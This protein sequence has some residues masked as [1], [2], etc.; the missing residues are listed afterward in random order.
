MMKETPF[1]LLKDVQKK[2]PCKN[3]EAKMTIYNALPRKEYERVFM[4]KTAKE[5][6][7]TLIITHQGNSQVKNCKIDLLTQ[8]YKKFSIS[9]EETIDSGSDE[10]IYEEEE[11]EAFN[12]MER[13]F[14]KFFRKGN[15]FGRGNQ[16][17]N[18]ANRFEN[19]VEIV[20]G[21]KKVKAQGKRKFATI[22]GKKGLFTSQSSEIVER[23]H[24][25]LRKMSHAMLDEQSIPQKWNP[26]L[27]YFRVF[28]CKVFILKTKVHLTK[29]DPKSYKG[30]FLGY[31]QSS[32]EYIVL[33]KE[34]IRIEESLNV[35]FAEPKSSPSVEDDRIIKLVVQNLVRS[36]LLKDNAPELGYPKSLK[37]ARGHQIEQVI[38]TAGKVCVTAAKQNLVLF[39]NLNGKNAKSYTSRSDK[40]SL[41]LKELMELCTNL[42]NMVL[43]L[44]TTKDTQA[45]KIEILK[46]RV[47]KLEKKQ[48]SRTHKLNRLYKVGLTARV[49]SSDEASL[50]EDASKQGRI[51]DDIDANEGITLVDETAENQKRFNDQEDAEML[52]DVADDLRGEEVFVSQE[53]P[54]KEVAAVDDVNAASIATTISAAV[55]IITEEVT[56]AKALAELKASKTKKVL[57][58]KSSRRKEE[59]TTN[60]S[61]TKKNHCAYL[62]N[63]EGNKLKDLKNK[64]FNSIQKMFDRA[65]KRVNT[66]VDYKTELVVES[67]KEAEAKLTE[68]SSKRAGEELEQENAKKQKMEDDKES[69]KLKQCLEIIPEDGDDVII[70]AT[71]LY[72]KSLIIVDYKI[73]KEGRK[74]YFQ[75]F[76]ADG[77]SQMYLTFSKMLKNFDREDLEV[78]WRL[79]KARFEKI[80]P[81]DNMDNL[82]LHNLKTMFE[83]HVEDNV[84]KNQQGLV[85][86]LN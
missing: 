66:F 82:L 13:N 58:N 74:S 10:D 69:S 28:G 86:V 63:M 70:D 30:V 44:E 8:E 68:D 84:W 4:C 6:C 23:T 1:E 18:G 48:R 20:V 25:K 46:R 79:V 72:F 38:V 26:S 85:K 55:T 62:K 81:V 77:N 22:V 11:A 47:K 9:N 40:D 61:S 42:Q 35:S 21:T 16:F 41:K 12:L 50:G 36:S 57:C 45:M 29:F 7:H 67:S 49:D 65:F 59:Q 51:I 78:L 3:N 17:G 33:N 83:H 52:F 24:R 73:Y 5:V 2:K 53:V 43:D 54:L 14:R 60:T 39:S 56:L 15:R 32:K 64:S 80:K 76:R 37:E 31:S 75:I 19:T 27:E 71:P 34:T